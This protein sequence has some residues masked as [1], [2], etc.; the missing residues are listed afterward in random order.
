MTTEHTTAKIGVDRQRWDRRYRQGA[1]AQR[2]WP[3]AYLKQL[4]DK[5]VIGSRGRA[6]DLAC[7]RGRNSLFLASIGFT[8]DAVDIAAAGIAQGVRL[9]LQQNLRVNWQCRDLLSTTPIIPAQRYA[10]IVMFRFVAPNLL[11]ILLD[12]LEPGGVLVVEEHMQ[13]GGKEA[14]LGPGSNRFRVCP[15]DL[16]SQMHVANIEFDVRDAYE[17]LVAEQAD[18]GSQGHAAISRMCIQRRST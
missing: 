13:W 1:Y 7:G 17:G 3:S 16:A 14:L 11:P 8:V 4:C 5:G 18:D 2:P 6:L 15:G 10:L 9:A 12:A